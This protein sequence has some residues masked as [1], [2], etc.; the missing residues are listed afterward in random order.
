MK[1]TLTK[2]LLVLIICTTGNVAFAQSHNVMVYGTV[3]KKSD[4]QGANNYINYSFRAT[5]E[6]ESR[7]VANDLAAQLESEYPNC[8][9]HVNRSQV[10]YGDDA[11][12]MVII[13]YQK[14]PDPYASCTTKIYVVKFGKT[15]DEALSLA[16]N[17]K[18]EYSS[19]DTPYTL[20]LQR[21]F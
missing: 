4:C 7:K 6:N 11:H 9:V 8:E 19:K 16:E 15:L 13:S 2:L 1:K 3:S 14:K 10:D 18:N 5:S 20:L 12:S 17:I 21:S